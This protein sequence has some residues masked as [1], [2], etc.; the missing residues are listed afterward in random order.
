MTTPAAK[1]SASGPAATLCIACVHR[2]GADCTAF[3]QGIPSEILF[4]GY[5]HRREY[6]GDH[7]I[8]FE[9][10]RGAERDLTE[11]LLWKAQA[12]RAR[13]EAAPLPN[14]TPEQVKAFL[15]IADLG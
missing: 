5:D 7:G 13:P 10:R 4:E 6:P 11:Y 9:V 2:H 3:P 14:L 15:E 12:P 8:R 1:G